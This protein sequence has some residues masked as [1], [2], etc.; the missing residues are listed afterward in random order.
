MAAG[1]MA[2]VHFGRLI[3]PAGFSRVVAIKRLHAHFAQDPQ[4]VSMLLDEARLAARIRHPNVVPTLD[5][6][7]DQGE[8]FIVMDYVHGESLARLLQVATTAGERIP[9]S[10][11]SAIVAGALHGLHAAHEATGEDGQPLAIIHR[12]VSPQNVLVGTDGAPRLLDFGVAKAASRVQSTAVGQ[13]KGKLAYMAPEQLTGGTATRQVDVFAAGVVLWEALTGQRLFSAIDEASTLSNVLVKEIEPPSKVVPGLPDGLDA[14]VLRGLD[15]NPKRRFATAREMA[16]ALEAAVRPCTGAELGE[17]VETMAASTLA[18]RTRQL[19]GIERARSHG[20]LPPELE[21]D[22]LSPNALVEVAEEAPEP[23]PDTVREEAPTAEAVDLEALGVLPARRVTRRS[24]AVALAAALVLGSIVA[25]AALRGTKAE[26]PATASA[27]PA[28][29]ATAATVPARA[30]VPTAMLVPPPPPPVE[31]AVSAAPAGDAASA[32]PV[33]TSRPP[34]ATTESPA[35]LRAACSP[36][37][38]VDAAGIRH[39]KPECLR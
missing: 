22:S 38:T 16:L 23:K 11:V 28:S 17:W 2:R 26:S 37:Y 39:I 3:G 30:A 19:Q 1:G 24:L 6:V 9:P 27:P 25:I 20:S 34:R 5:V 18:T 12:D 35:P 4:F 10:H 31:P 33:P 36:P 21:P 29:S 15:R 7:A 32:E 14:V 13:L 8:L